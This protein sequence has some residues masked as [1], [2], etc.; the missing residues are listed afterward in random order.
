MYRD[1][2]VGM[3]DALRLYSD[4]NDES[5]EM[6]RPW[7]A[8]LTDVAALLSGSDARYRRQH[9]GDAEREVQLHAVALLVD[10]L[11]CRDEEAMQRALGDWA[12]RE[13]VRWRK[14]R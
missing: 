9:E 12:T 11:A 8:V 3:M 4:V 14:G 13:V 6:H 2:V 1:G 7:F 5:S 10:G